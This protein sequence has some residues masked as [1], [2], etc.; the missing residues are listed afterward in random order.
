[1]LGLPMP[2][3]VVQVSPRV[4]TVHTR[5]HSFPIGLDTAIILINTMLI[6]IIHKA[7]PQVSWD[8]FI[9]HV[10]LGLDVELNFLF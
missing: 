4:S 5:E 10:L 2:P 6:M 7:K 9:L 8:S 1:M 3:C